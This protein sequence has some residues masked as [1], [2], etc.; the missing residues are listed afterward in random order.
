MASN[1]RAAQLLQNRRLGALGVLSHTLLLTGVRIE[2]RLSH[3]A[4]SSSRFPSM[5][6]R[7]NLSL[8]MRQAPSLAARSIS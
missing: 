6:F 7:L 4:F 5:N 3:V 8:V 1:Q 2:G